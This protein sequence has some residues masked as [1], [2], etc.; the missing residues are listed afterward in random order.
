M[1]KADD[2]TSRLSAA[3]PPIT[4]FIKKSWLVYM[5]CKVCFGLRKYAFEGILS[6]MT[7]A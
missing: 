6:P 7:T 4:K 1:S 5:L 3:E 2:A